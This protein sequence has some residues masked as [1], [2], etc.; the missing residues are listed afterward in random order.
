VSYDAANAALAGAA[1]GY[2]VA[3]PV[4]AMSLLILDTGLRRGLP[5][6]LA[7]G[8]G[9]ALADLGYATAAAAGGAALA[10][11]PAAALAAGA[12]EVAARRG[13]ISFEFVGK[14]TQ[15]GAAFSGFGYLTRV[16]GLPVA[17]LFADAAVQ[18]ER[19]AHFTFFSAAKLTGRS[20]LHNLE[21]LD[22][23]GEMAFYHRA[24]PG[25]DFGDPGSFARGRRI[26]LFDAH[27]LSVVTEQTA[28]EGSEDLRGQLTQRSA[29]AFPLGGH[30]LRF[31]RRG[32]RQA[33]RANGW[34]QR[35]SAVGPT[36]QAWVA[37]LAR[38][39]AG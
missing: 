1:A 24:R 29:P 39:A 2:A 11:P 7:A 36:S 5:P 3:L 10:A 4:G 30:E 19:T 18:S 21:V 22:A 8:F 13:E 16:A 9:V 14:L 34:S 12:G 38:L 35:L 28:S 23:D 6:A 25:A 27:F 26:A 15:E 33:I 17:A 32:T 37:G 31:G 20:E